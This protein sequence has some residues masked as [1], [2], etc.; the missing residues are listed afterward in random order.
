MA[1]DYDPFT[2]GEHPVGVR[3]ETWTD[4][5][6]GC[7]LT[8]EIWYPA[9]P[10]HAGQ[11]L[12]PT[13]QD[14][15]PPVWGTHD[16]PAS[17]MPP[18]R[19]T[20]VRDAQP[21]A[22]PGTLVVFSH[23][24]AGWRREATFVCT[25]LA[26]HG[27]VVVGT[28]H[29]ESTSWEVDA[30]LTSPDPIAREDSR[31]LM[32]AQRKGDVPFL[33]AEAER[34][35]YSASGD[36]GFT[37]ISLGGWTT[38]IAPSVE[39]RVRVIAAMCPAGGISPIAPGRNVLAEELDLSWPKGVQ[40]LHM[41]AD[42]DAWL[43]LYGHLGMFARFSGPSRMA[44]LLDADHNHFVDDIP[45]SHAWYR[46]LTWELAKTYPDG[47]TNWAA[48]AQTIA[49]IED[50]VDADVAYELWRGL[51]VAQ[52]DAHLRDRPEARQLLEERLRAEAA[53]VGA[54]VLTIEGGSA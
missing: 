40:C 27:Y 21:A 51:T 35:G 9:H 44:I 1:Q 15:Y 3:T 32:A 42:R 20:A 13:T 7:D 41:V 2:R 54:R 22:L 39:P 24:Y 12:D 6:R 10:A 33:V 43:P 11:D 18:V 45:T 52:F 46:E 53:R 34:R 38:L 14:S 31:L 26:S 25:H 8:V 4:T 50:L 49:P 29:P 5:V 28:D 17:E 37:G 36:V 48:I 23:G 47:D 30:T 19:Q 16:A